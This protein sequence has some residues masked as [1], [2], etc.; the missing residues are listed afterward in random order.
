MQELNINALAVGKQTAQ[1]TAATT[2][3]KRLIWAGG[4]IAFSRDDG[5]E[6]YSDLGKFGSAT[7]WVNNVSGAGTP[8]IQATP[9]ELAYLLYLFEGGETTTAVTGPPVKT[10]HTFVPLPGAGFWTTWFR[11]VGASQIQ[12]QNYVDSRIGQIVIEGSTAQKVVK[13]TPSV[14]SLDPAVVVAADPVSAATLPVKRPFIYTEGTGTFTI[15]TLV[16]RGHSQFTLTSNADLSVVYGDDTTGYA[17]VSGNPRV[18]LGCTIYMDADGLAQYNRLVYGTA[19][20]AAGTK[21]LKTIPALGSYGFTLGA[22]T[23]STGVANGDIYKLTVPG[24]KW[25]I[26]PAPAPSQGG[27]GAEIALAG[28]MRVVAGQPAYTQDVTCDAAAFV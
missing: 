7:D 14:I 27:G 13:V 12:R 2:T 24:V 9:E 11:R 1:G 4:D 5:N 25:A 26:P 17:V 10:K 23:P 22:L 6:E 15:D 3:M 19:T 20:P 28:E 18:T 8:A 16:Q 21:P